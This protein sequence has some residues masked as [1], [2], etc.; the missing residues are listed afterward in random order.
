MI[1]AALETCCR[2][3]ELLSLPRRDMSLER[4]EI[5]LRASN[6]KDEEDRLIPISARLH[7]IL[8]MAEIGP[9][10]EKLGPETFVFGD[11]IGGRVASITKAWRTAVLKAHGH[12][13]HW[14][15]GKGKLTP[16]CQAAYRAVDL[17]FHDLRHGGASRL[18]EGGWELHEVRDMLGH[19]SVDQTSTYLNTTVGRLKASMRRLDKARRRRSCKRVASTLTVEPRPS[20][21]D[22]ATKPSKLLVN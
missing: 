9:D 6:T 15:P 19:A 1:I 14:V 3:G 2:R 12:D 21:K 8:S 11:E 18:L 16:E 5:L 20:R 13:V 7:A 17:H 4:R 22:D 10:G